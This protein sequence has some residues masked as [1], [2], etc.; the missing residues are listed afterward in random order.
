MVTVSLEVV[1]DGLEI[2]VGGVEVVATIATNA[3]E[4]NSTLFGAGLVESGSSSLDY[5]LFI[6]SQVT[7]AVVNLL[8]ISFLLVIA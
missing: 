3:L 8:A 7:V 2:A 5:E 6:N 4:T 1:A